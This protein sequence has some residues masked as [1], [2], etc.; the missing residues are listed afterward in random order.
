[1]KKIIVYFNNYGQD[2]DSKK[3]KIFHV[4][5]QLNRASKKITKVDQPYQ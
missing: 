4:S 1:L 5:I 3:A 2:L